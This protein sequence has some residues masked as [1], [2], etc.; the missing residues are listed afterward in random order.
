ML[1]PGVVDSVVGIVRCAA[2]AHRGGVLWRAPTDLQP[3]LRNALMPPAEAAAHRARSLPLP[4]RS[5]G[6][7]CAAVLAGQQSGAPGVYADVGVLRPWI[8]QTMAALLGQQPAC[9]PQLGCAVCATPT[10]CLTC[11]NPAYVVD[12]ASGFCRP[13]DCRDDPA[14]GCELCSVANPRALAFGGRGGARAGVAGRGLWAV[15]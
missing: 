2:A 8:D 9:P 11:A 3:P 15:G 12:A 5:Y 13:V 6:A 10:R 1:V 14:K 7:D 4:Q